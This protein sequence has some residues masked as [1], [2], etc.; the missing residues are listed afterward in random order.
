MKKI[1]ALFSLLFVLLCSVHAQ[2]G[3]HA[4]GFGLNY[5]TQIESM[6]LGVKYQYNITDPI[7]IEPSFNYFFEND[8][9]SMLDLNVNLHYLFPVGK[10]VKIYPLFGLTLANWMLDIDDVLLGYD[11]DD[12]ECRFG[13]NLGGG[14]EFDLGRNWAI[15]LEGKY[16]LVSDFDQGVIS[17][18]AVYRF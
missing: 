4:L 5:G 11:V 12:N 8:N 7:R 2:Q 13:V 3:R 10:G 15:N 14:V 6:G 16:Q 17:L 9:V 18:G 1:F